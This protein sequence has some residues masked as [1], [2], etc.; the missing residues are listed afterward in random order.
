MVEVLQIIEKF[1][2]NNVLKNM[3]K[4][5]KETVKRLDKIESRLASSKEISKDARPD[6][7]PPITELDLLQSTLASVNIQNLAPQDLS[8][9]D[10]QIDLLISEITS[11]N[12]E[13][14]K[15]RKSN[16]VLV[17]KQKTMTT[18]EGTK[19]FFCTW[20]KETGN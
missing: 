14:E 15:L 10:N 13:I 20:C 3:K 17:Q 19:R 1:D 11:K 5:Q 18:W 12:K 4:I 9:K 2:V 8:Y 7:S 16:A 6:I